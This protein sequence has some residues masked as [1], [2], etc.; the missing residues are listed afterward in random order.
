MS[1]H[2]TKTIVIVLAVIALALAGANYRAFSFIRGEHVR[3]SELRADAAA[4]DERNAQLFGTGEND[5]VAQV[6]DLNSHVLT[7][8]DDSV[9]FIESLEARAQE[10][11]T[12]FE[13]KSVGVDPITD[14][15]KDNV[16]ET[17][18][19]NFEATS[20]W[21]SVAQFIF[22]LEHMPYRV[23]I[24]QA[25]LSRLEEQKTSPAGPRWRLRAEFT[26]LKQK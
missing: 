13:I 20:L 11:N 6:Q 19:L 2:K 16:T 26:V 5:V 24:E 1:T 14:D 10:F 18:R 23:V 21:E 25:A 15:T 22:A 9:A 12:A 17:L 4:F 7:A 8:S 3:A